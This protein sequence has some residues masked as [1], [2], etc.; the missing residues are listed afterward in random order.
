MSRKV[1]F[2]GFCLLL[3]ACA[4]ATPTPIS[5]PPST[6]IPRPTPTYTILPTLTPTHSPAPTPTPTYTYRLEEI[7]SR[8]QEVRCFYTCLESKDFTRPPEEI[9]AKRVWENPRYAV[10]KV[11]DPVTKRNLLWPWTH[12]FLMYYDGTSTAFHK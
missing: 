8:G 5:M 7:L 9:Q 2:I 6:V 10:S 11:Q 12:N 3:T 1:L 4:I